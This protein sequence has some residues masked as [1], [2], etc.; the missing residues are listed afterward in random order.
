MVGDLLEPA[1]KLSALR[2]QELFASL[3]RPGQR[4]ELGLD[5]GERILWVEAST[6]ATRPSA[7]DA[8]CVESPLSRQHE[9]LAGQ[10]TELL[11]FFRVESQGYAF[12]SQ[13]LGYLSTD[14]VGADKKTALELRRPRSVHRFSRREHI[15][16]PLDGATAMLTW[17]AEEAGVT[18]VTVEGRVQDVS[19][20]GA[21][22]ALSA[23][24][25]WLEEEFRRAPR[26]T[27]EFELVKGQPLAIEAGVAWLRIERQPHRRVCLGLTWRDAPP[28]AVE[29]IGRVVKQRRRDAMR[30]GLEA[31]R[32]RK[33]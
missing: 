10:E 7:D 12:A 6:S 26:L 27:V 33:R 21:A 9:G 4:L 11:V 30:G 15:R 29:A 18:P 3:S 8:F 14:R 20:G 17:V 5:R 28:T 2:A 24:D 32:A 1:D 25:E 16:A 31:V 19:V 23:V 13:V 22:V